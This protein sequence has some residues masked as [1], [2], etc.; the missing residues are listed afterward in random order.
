MIEFY[1]SMI[2]IGTLS[3]NSEGLISAE[4]NDNK[5]PFVMEGKRLVLPTKEMLRL[6]D[7]SGVVLFHPLSE[8]AL[9]GESDVMAKFRSAVNIKLNY[10]LATICEELL[11]VV[12]SVAKHAKLSPDQADLL[13]AVKNADEKTLTVFKAILKAMGMGNK[14]K[15]IVYL[16]LRKQALIKEKTYARAAV[17]WFPLLDELLKDEKTVFG[18]AVRT[19]D[20]AALIQLLQ[21]VLPGISEKNTYSRGSTSDIAPFLDSLLLAVLGLASPVNALVNNYHEFLSNAKEL[22]YDDEWVETFENLSLLLPEIRMTPMQAG[23]NGS[24]N[25]PAPMPQQ[26]LMYQQPMQPMPGMMPAYAQVYGQPM[27]QVAP[28]NTITES[29]KLDFAA[30]L[31]NNPALNAQYTPPQAMMPQQQDTPVWAHP[32]MQQGMMNQGFQQP[33]GFPQGNYNGMNNTGHFRI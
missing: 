6:E 24:F 17:V 16:Y 33:M 30:V 28:A 23:N 27:Q 5:V 11:N 15:C 1:Q 7:K 2:S 14:D 32:P 9:A 21:F 31:R 29:G 13:S 22:A 18:V 25:A 8:N 4:L 3:A 26:P 20:K 19:K 12:V 10:S